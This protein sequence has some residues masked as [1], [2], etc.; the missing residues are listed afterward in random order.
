MTRAAADLPWDQSLTMEEFAEPQCFTT[1]AF[2]SVVQTL[3]RER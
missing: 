2:Q 1:D 3:L